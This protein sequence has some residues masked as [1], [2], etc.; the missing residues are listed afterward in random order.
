[1]KKQVG[2]EALAIAVPRRYVDIEDLARARGVEPAKYTAGLGAKEMA[3]ADPGED[4]VA[5]AASAVSRLIQRHGVDPSRV[6][7]LVV[8]TETGV[9]HSKPVASHVQGLLKLPRSMRT[10]DA[11]HACYGGTAGLMAA[12]EWI[13]SGAGAGRSA[14]VVC[15]D[16]A[17]YGL[18][19]AGEPTQGGGAVALLVSEQ[20]D[21]LALDIGLNGVCSVDVYDFWRP[22]GRR[23]A[24]VD[25]HYSI[26]CYLDALSGAYRGWR[27]RAMAHEV[28]RWGDSLP[29]EQLA[30]I[31][32][33]VPF[34]KM[35]RK[36]HTQL[37]LCDLEDA[38]GAQDSTPAAREEAAKSSASYEAQ[39]ASSL[40]LNA[41]IGNVYT[42]SLYLALAGLLHDEGA[43]LAGKRIGL[44]SYGSGCCA[45]F[46]SGVVGEGAARRMAQSDVESVLAKRERVSIEEYER[47]MRLASD[48]PE[49]LTPAPGE[50]RLTEIREHRRIYA[51]G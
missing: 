20:P 41:R 9:D 11:Q 31:L 43:A 12:T 21:L 27:E 15:S 37:R 49:P 40:G 16:I 5:L 47:I 34:C 42:A 17:R 22:L 7:M 29:G 19:T 24:V 6:G 35:A 25:G 38:P 51:A 1:M 48:A 28:V 3:V 50:F 13:A 14:I 18:N 30:R 44:L 46:Y 8:G 26:S 45:E 4:S 10:F 39:V 23:E 2:I 33:H 32:Y 36:A